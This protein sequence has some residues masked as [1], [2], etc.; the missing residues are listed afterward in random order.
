VCLATNSG[1]YES[2]KGVLPKGLSAMILTTKL[3]NQP[4]IAE[5]P[6]PSAADKMA[7]TKAVTV[8]QHRHCQAEAGI[9]QWS[10]GEQWQER[11]PGLGQAD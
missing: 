2:P 8:R 4:T 11:A 9:P 1:D 6:K 10:L 5:R 3:L 7:I